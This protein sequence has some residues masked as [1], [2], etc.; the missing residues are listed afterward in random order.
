MINV[1]ML[2]K[3]RRMHFR[4]HIPVR[5]IAKRTGLS[6]NTIRAWLRQPDVVEPQYPEREV[7]SILDPYKEQLATWLRADS[8]RSMGQRRTVL[9]LFHLLRAQGYPGGYGRVAAFARAW[10]EEQLLAPT[11]K[12]FVPLQFEPPRYF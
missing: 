4:D 8:H 2:A 7:H 5:E 6:R 1:G 9:Q 11:R 12:A 10:R 3:I